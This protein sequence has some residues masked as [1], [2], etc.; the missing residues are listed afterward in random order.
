MARVAKQYGVQGL[1]RGFTPV[2]IRD[3]IY[4]GGLLGITPILQV[5]LCVDCCMSL[6]AQ[7]HLI[8]DYQMSTLQSGDSGV[9]N[10][11]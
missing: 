3:A 8:Q 2:A 11:H 10:S 5:N 9:G 6:G 7:R 1:F 4:V